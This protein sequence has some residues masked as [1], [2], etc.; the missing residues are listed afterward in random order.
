MDPLIACD[1]TST[2]IINI[3]LL[4]SYHRCSVNQLMTYLMYAL[5]SS[6]T[7]ENRLH[8]LYRPCAVKHVLNALKV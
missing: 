1:E 4:A 5:R 3:E 2:H 7:F 6:G 8:G